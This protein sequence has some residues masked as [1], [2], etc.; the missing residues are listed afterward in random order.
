MFS[1]EISS[2]RMFPVTNMKCPSLSL[3]INFSLRF[4][5]LDIRI[6]TPAC[7]LGP[8]DWNIFF[9]NFYC[10]TMSLRLV[11][12]SWMQMKDGFCFHI[13]SVNLYLLIGDMS[14]FTLRDNNEQGLLS[15]ANLVF[16]VGN[17]NLCVFPFFGIWCYE[18]INCLCFCWCSQFPWAGGFFLVFCVGLGLW[19]GIG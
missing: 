18:T 4:I 2:W 15:P 12:V 9:P 1:I 19:L 13:Q 6:A 10:E 11:C 5:L 8:F 17:V 14:A 16:I 3:L 7:F